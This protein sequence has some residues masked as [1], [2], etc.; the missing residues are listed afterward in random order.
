[1]RKNSEEWSQ[2]GGNWRKGSGSDINR[3]DMELASVVRVEVSDDEIRA[4]AEDSIV[5]TDGQK[6]QDSKERERKLK[7]LLKGKGFVKVKSDGDRRYVK[8]AIHQT[9]FCSVVRRLFC[10]E[11]EEQ[12]QVRDAPNLRLEAQLGRED[13]TNRKVNKSIRDQNVGR[14][15]RIIPV[16]SDRPLRDVKSPECDPNR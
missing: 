15:R 3:S 4:I 13:L 11:A 9:S 8:K 5:P 14:K 16:L 7:A 10:L 1:M 2:N 12:N 6:I